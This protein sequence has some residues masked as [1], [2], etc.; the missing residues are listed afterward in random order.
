MVLHLL[1]FGPVSVFGGQS[2]VEEDEAEELRWK[3]C[4]E[5][6]NLEETSENAHTPP[7]TH[8]FIH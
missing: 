5:L 2:V 8:S 1:Q 3:S 6:K 4:I 7:F